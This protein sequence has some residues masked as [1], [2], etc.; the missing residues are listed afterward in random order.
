MTWTLNKGQ[1]RALREVLT[2]GARNC[3]LYGGA[4]SGKTA[5]LVSA[6]IDR[7]L[8]A[9]GSRHLIVRAEASAARRS[10]GLQTFPDVWGKKYPGVSVPRLDSQTGRIVLPNNS[11]IWI[12]GMSDQL[13][14]ERILGQEYATIFINEATEIGYD[15]VQVL[16]TRLAQVCERDAAGL[17]GELPQRL[18]ADCNP[19]TV[20]HWTYKLWIEGVDPITGAPVDRAQYAA[21]QINPLDNADNLS[22]DFIAEMEALPPAARKRFFLGEYSVDS[23]HGLWRRETIKRVYPRD[24]GSLP[25]EMRR[26]VIG[27]D[28]AVTA[29]M[30]SDETGIIV[31]G[32]GMDGRGYVID[33]LSGRMRPEEWAERVAAAWRVHNADRVIA[34]VNNGGDLVANQIR[35]VSPG[36]AIQEV[37]A[38][39]GKVTR[40]EPVAAL[41][42]MGKILH[43][44]EHPELEDQMCALT[45]GFDA[46]AAGWS[47]DRV[48]ALVW[49]VTALFPSL[50]AS[51]GTRLDAP[52]SEMP[53]PEFVIV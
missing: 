41:Y 42:H 20:H 53:L 11:E 13:Q 12:G 40:A 32:L 30:N 51:G 35:A 34:E 29:T 38:S 24:D 9:S 19:T 10:I 49:A 28:P 43:V 27:V 45:P 33:D 46:R 50:A 7:A 39:R 26:I 8:T 17:K 47:P 4:R 48:D 1:K 36:I 21:A 6:T 25:V 44:G 15:R 5:L 23:E 3:L 31:A 18:Y 16:R 37:R 14:T 2:S 22:P 52:A